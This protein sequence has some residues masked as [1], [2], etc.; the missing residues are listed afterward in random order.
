MIID[1]KKAKGAAITLTYS[2]PCGHP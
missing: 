2:P 1:P